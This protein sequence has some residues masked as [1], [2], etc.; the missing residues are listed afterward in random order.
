[1]ANNLSGTDLTTLVDEH[2]DALLRFF[3]ASGVPYA[4]AT[5][6]VQTT[7]ETLISKDAATIRKPQHYLWGIARL[8]LLQFKERY[9][10]TEE[11]RSSRIVPQVVTSPSTRLD[12]RVRVLTLLQRLDDDTRTVFLLRCE[13]LTLDAIATA[14]D[15]HV[16]T[17]KRKLQEARRQID[18]IASDDP[19]LAGAE[20][21]SVDDVEDSYR[22]D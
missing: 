13:G 4:D 5:D 12:R 14:T 11:Y 10:P 16:S 18:R 21:L 3:S 17:V 22:R 9:R 1:M 20:P 8:K 15:K 19:A 6:L 2:A 7:F